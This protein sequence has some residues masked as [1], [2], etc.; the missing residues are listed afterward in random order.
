VCQYVVAG[1]SPDIY[2][3]TA[4][5]IEGPSGVDPDSVPSFASAGPIIVV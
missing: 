4:A 2:T 1:P 5:L 3:L